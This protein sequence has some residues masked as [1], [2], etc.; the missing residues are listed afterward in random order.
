MEVYGMNAVLHRAQILVEALPYIQK[1]SGKIVVVKYGGSTRNEDSTSFFQDLVMMKQVNIHPVVVHGG[2]PEITALLESMGSQVQFVN[3]LRV[4]D[5]TVLDAASM[6]LVGKI[7]KQIVSQIQSYGGNAIGLSGIDGKLLLAE[8]KQSKDV[9]LG[10]VGEIKEVNCTLLRGLIE[11]GY[12]PVISPLG[13]DH[14]GQRYNINAD[15]VAA[16]VAG[17]LNA[18]KLVLST[19]VAGLYVEENGEK[20]TISAIGAK[21]I[22]EYIASGQIHGGMVPK[23]QACLEALSRG[24]QRTHIVDGRQE[25]VLLLELLTDT[26]VGTMVTKEDDV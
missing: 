8:K 11:Q 2:G 20:Q 4:T 1:F 26:G 3:G 5:H 25:H 19:N 7:N 22:A 23:V 17:A 12:I 9:D 16:V 6:V 15:T 24:V 21:K 13:V 14:Q 18:E 10:Y